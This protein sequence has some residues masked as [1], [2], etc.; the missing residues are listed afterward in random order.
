M[1]VEEDE[2]RL[3]ETP[4]VDVVVLPG[5]TNAYNKV[6]F[7]MNSEAWGFDPLTMGI[8]AISN[9]MARTNSHIFIADSNSWL[10]GNGTVTGL[11]ECVEGVLLKRMYEQL[12]DEGCREL[13]LTEDLYQCLNETN[14]LDWFYWAAL[15]A[16][17]LGEGKEPLTRRVQYKLRFTLL[18]GVPKKRH[19]ELSS[20]R[21]GDGARY[22]S[23]F[24]R[25][26][27]PVLCERDREVVLRS[28]ERYANKDLGGVLG[29]IGIK[30]TNN[31]NAAA[32]EEL[33]K[34]YLEFYGRPTIS[35]P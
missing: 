33:E 35:G 12:P 23:S 32:M 6:G 4:Y 24:Y 1:K 21:S 2:R 25:P 3:R 31:L 16:S 29:F 19:V 28:M 9:I 15:E 30:E 5:I 22:L 11:M 10:Q 14:S 8:Q 17:R 18:R 26:C 20:Y 13:I 34:L 7:S 27:T